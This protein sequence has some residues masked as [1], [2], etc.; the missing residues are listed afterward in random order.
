MNKYDGFVIDYVKKV[1]CDPGCTTLEEELR[2]AMCEK[3][4]IKDKWA[5][6]LVRK[7]CKRNNSLHLAKV[8]VLDA[9]DKVL[10][11]EWEVLWVDQVQ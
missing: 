5:Y 4:S 6:E 1:Q 10:G 2:A 8:D 3:F 11:Q 7:I 9:N